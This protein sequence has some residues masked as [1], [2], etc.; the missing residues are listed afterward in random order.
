MHWSA[1]RSEISHPHRA[2]PP[3]RLD[4][5]IRGRSQNSAPKIAAD[6]VPKRHPRTWI[7]GLPA[8]G[9]QC[10]LED[11]G[12]LAE[13]PVHSPELAFEQV[14]GAAQAKF[15]EIEPCRHA[16][17]HFP[18]VSDFHFGRQAWCSRTQ[19]DSFPRRRRSRPGAERSS[20]DMPSLA[21]SL[22][23]RRGRSP[24]PPIPSIPAINA[25]GSSQSA[26]SIGL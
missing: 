12:S 16:C 24:G 5:Q 4:G 10:I 20:T 23:N 21:I 17:T 22:R 18:V 3:S 25:S 13:D 9:R 11:A 7:E 6:S 1:F 8:G 14:D 2:E 15:Q 19:K 26:P